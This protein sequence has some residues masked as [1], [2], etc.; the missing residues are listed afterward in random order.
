MGDNGN[1][2]VNVTNGTD[3]VSGATVTLTDSDSQTTS[4]TTD[5]DGAVEF[6]DVPNGEYTLSIAK[7]GYQTETDTVTVAGSDLT[8]NVVLTAIDTLTIKVDD[9]TDAIEGASVV[10]GETSKTTDSSGECTFTDM[11][12]DDYSAEVSATGYT[13]K[14]ESIAFRSNHKS[15]TISLTAE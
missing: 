6:E 15:F 1:I 9:G 8:V 4:E 3:A 14:T 13:T 11:P 12:Y 10:I 5:S 2:A 7:E